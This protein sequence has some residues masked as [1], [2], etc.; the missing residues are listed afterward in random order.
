MKVEVGDRPWLPAPNKPYG[1]YGRKA[2]LKPQSSVKVEVGDRP[3]L[4]VPNKPYGLCGRKATA[5]T[6]SGLPGTPFV[7][8]IRAS[9]NHDWLLTTVRY[10]HSD[11]TLDPGKE[12]K[13]IYN[14]NLL[15]HNP[16]T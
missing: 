10:N 6:V 5:T 14:K 13:A 8:V 7:V 9:M 3:V 12:L 11:L 1:L 16:N 2:T 4:P 15:R